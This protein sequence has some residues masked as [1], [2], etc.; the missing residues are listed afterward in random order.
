MAATVFLQTEPS[1]LSSTL[2][3]GRRSRLVHRL[4]GATGSTQSRTAITP[5][6]DKKS[7]SAVSG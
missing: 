1:A 3:I 6:G 7:R 5:S 2:R 4:D